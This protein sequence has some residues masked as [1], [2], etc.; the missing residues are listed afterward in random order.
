M[1]LAQVSSLYFNPAVTAVHFDRFTHVGLIRTEPADGKVT[2][3]AAAGTSFASGVKTYNAAIG[4]D[5]DTARVET[6]VERASR[7]GALTG[8]VATSSIVHA[9]PAAFY[10]H[11]AS[12]NQ[13]EDIA[14][15]LP[16]S[17]VDFF[18]GGGTQFFAGRKDGR[19]V[20]GELVK[21]GFAMD[22]VAL[23][24]AGRLHP[25]QRYGFLLA[26]DAMPRML[27]GRGTFLSDA[28]SRALEYL[29]QGERGFFLM[30]E[31]SQIDW[32]GHAN[33]VEYL[34]S[35]MADFNEAVGVVLDF[36]ARDR[37][38]L[39]VVTADHETG[40]LS[41]SSG[42]GYDVVVPTFSTGGHSATLIPVFAFGPGAES[43][44]G[45]HENTVVFDRL[46]SAFGW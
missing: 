1:G 39:V 44:Q 7:A 30:V 12:R 13:Y 20:F 4:V 36:A 10:A 22:T 16:I 46:I 15:F 3:S 21:A 23:A 40:G 2:D 29:A 33:D 35:E 25:P 5:V 8:L 6:I 37:Q 43:F 28:T 32:G 9:T 19:D 42:E 27:D 34:Y 18:A 41:L 45:V 38:T 14:A 17:E 11:V 31:G 24:P 26:R